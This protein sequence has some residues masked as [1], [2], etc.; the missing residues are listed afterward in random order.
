VHCTPPSRLSGSRDICERRCFG[1]RQSAVSS[2]QSLIK[3]GCLRGR[4]I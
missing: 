1:S 3:V 2:R 4:N